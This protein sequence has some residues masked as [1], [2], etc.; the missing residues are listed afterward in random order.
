M[1]IETALWQRRS[2]RDYDDRPV[3]P[4]ILHRLID[5]A[6]QAP[7]AMNEQ[8]WTFTVVRDPATLDRLSRDAK[9][10][11]LAT[12]PT[13]G[14]AGARSG[15][16]QSLLSDPKFHIFYHAPVLIIIAAQ[17][18][19]SWVTEDCAMAAQNLMLAAYG[20]GL[21]SCWIGFAQRYLN[22]PAGKQSLGIPETSVP[23]A[24]IILGHPRT[25]PAPVPR[26]PPTIQWVD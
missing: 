15:R 8:P 20:S 23:V 6:I 7:S 17:A 1:D 26:R 13:D 22:T 2:V 3:D 24:P 19:G 9:T 12:I 16:F 21:G 11:T 18:S 4:S 5:A 25:L 14:S 10:H